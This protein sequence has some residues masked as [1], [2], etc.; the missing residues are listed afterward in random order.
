M[1]IKEV[2]YVWKNVFKNINYSFLMVFIALFFYALTALIS[3]ISNIKS[4]SSAYGIINGIGFG[5]GII[6]R[7]H[8]TTLP[9]SLL[10]I[11]IISFLSGMLFTLLIYRYI[12]LKSSDNKGKLFGSLGIFI[13]IAAP[14]CAVCGIGLAALIGIGGSIASL[15]FQGMEIS[16]LAILI[17]C[18]SIIK[19][20]NNFLTCKGFYT[21][22]N[23]KKRG[24]KNERGK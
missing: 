6:Q 14:G 7:F 23:S 3:N 18:Y 1:G 22:D 21:Y 5:V 17:L 12:V 13:G 8:Q 11:L 16:W 24:I 9:S 10:T 4:F 2:F 15:P 19:I 20:S